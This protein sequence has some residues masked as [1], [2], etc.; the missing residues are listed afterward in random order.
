MKSTACIY[1]ILISLIS[2]LNSG[3]KED[4]N[5][6]IDIEGAVYHCVTIGTRIWMV[7]NLKV[8]HYRNGDPIP[9]V[10]NEM[11]WDTLTIGAYCNYENEENNA[12]IYGRLYNWHAVNDTRKL[13]PDGWHIAT[14]TEYRELIANAG[15]EDAAGGNLKESGTTH[16]NPPNTNAKNTFGFT[17][18]P[19]GTFASFGFDGLGESGN[20]WSSTEFPAEKAFYLCLGHTTGRAFVAYQDKTMGN[21]VR[22]VRDN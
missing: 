17:A 14:E 22:C 12:K 5:D 6:V 11:E 15:A 21:A 7:E 3:C 1:S 19:S 2:I 9:N 18:L 16:W 8:T 13:A 20:L 10:T 4:E